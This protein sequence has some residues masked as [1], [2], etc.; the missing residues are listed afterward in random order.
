[1]H[2]QGMGGMVRRTYDPSKYAYNEAVNS[3]MRYPITVLAFML[4]LA[5]CIFFWNCWRSLKKGVVAGK[6]PWH[7]A[8][9]EWTTPSPAPHGNFGEALPVVSRG[10]YDYSLGE[11]EEGYLPQNVASGEGPLGGAAGG[12]AGATS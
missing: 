5:Q 4:F 1:M 8:T 6:N 9:L 7:A 2:F 3:T 12:P 10:P 11:D